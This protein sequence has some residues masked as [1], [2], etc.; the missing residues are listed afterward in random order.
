M[1][2][3]ILQKRRQGHH[4][5]FPDPLRNSVLLHVPLGIPP[6]EHPD[7]HHG[8]RSPTGLLRFVH[9]ERILRQAFGPARQPSC[10]PACIH[11]DHPCAVRPRGH[12]ARRDIP[13]LTHHRACPFCNHR[14]TYKNIP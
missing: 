3:R 13:I 6:V 8:H 4:L 5:Q 14:I 10:H 2:E 9:C 7:I 11:H 1:P 12:L